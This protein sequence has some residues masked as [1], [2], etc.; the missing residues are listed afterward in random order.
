M[1]M[2]EAQAHHAAAARHAAHLQIAMKKIGVCCNGVCINP[3]A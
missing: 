2:A 3:V 1:A